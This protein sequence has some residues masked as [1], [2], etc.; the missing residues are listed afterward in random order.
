MYNGLFN[1]QLEELRDHITRSHRLLVKTPVPYGELLTDAF[2]QIDNTLEELSVAEQT[3]LQQ[4]DALVKT[5][6]EIEAERLRYQH[7]FEFAPDGYIVTDPNGEIIEANRAASILLNVSTKHLLKKF[8]INYIQIEKRTNF[9]KDH[10][11]ASRLG[12]LP[13]IETVIQPRNG[14]PFTAAITVTAETD[15]DG[16]TISLRWLIRDITERKHHQRILIDLNTKLEKKVSERTMNLEAAV[17]RERDI[18]HTWQQS[19]L[20]GVPIDIITGHSIVTH[21]EAAF[22]DLLVGGDFYDVFKID[23]DNLAL[24]IGDVSGKGLI[25]ATYTAE[26]KYA[27]RAYMLMTKSPK[28]S[29][30]LLNAHLCQV[31]PLSNKNGDLF[32]VMIVAILNISSGTVKYAMAG[33]EPMVHISS[34]G[35][36]T[37]K[38][39]PALPLG[40]IKDNIYNECNFQI[41]HGDRLFMITDG[42]TEV[43]QDEE[44][45]GI[46]GLIEILQKSST[47]P[48]QKA[49][50]YILNQAH[51]YANG[52][53]RDDVCM[54]VLEKTP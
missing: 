9:R 34:D 54:L 41:R 20:P 27:N 25:A 10:A 21:Y 46:N 51:L 13:E 12:H 19:L 45:L 6:S 33:S 49:A 32:V 22:D 52:K 29:L 47:L 2:N 35:N 42:I 44:Y 50:D 5:R 18:T 53:L 4:N 36:T 14:K 48:I 30:T 26:V 7:L 28:D 11:I 17:Q 39:V 16:N 43:R 40:I 8:L 1:R 31:T 3:L 15:Y 37:V 24:V 38:H 23:N